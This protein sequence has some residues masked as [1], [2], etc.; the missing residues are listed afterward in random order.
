MDLFRKM[1]SRVALGSKC[2]SLYFV[3]MDQHLFRD[4]E[5]V[6]IWS[7]WL[8]FDSLLNISKVI[9]NSLGI[10]CVRF[11]DALDLKAAA[12]SYNFKYK[13]HVRGEIWL[14][15]HEHNL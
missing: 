1:K 14:P 9:H 6:S 3:I 11:F 2:N 12:Q 8:L 7:A 13:T 10:W 5:Q 15:R 4:V